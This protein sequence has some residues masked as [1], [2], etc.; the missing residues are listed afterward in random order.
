LA[1]ATSSSQSVSDDFLHLAAE[2]LRDPQSSEGALRSAISRAYYAVFISVRDQLFGPDATKLTKPI[3][4]QLNKRYQQVRRRKLELG[5]HDIIIFALTEI[6]HKTKLPVLTLSTQVGQLK[7][8]R[9]HAD[10]D[11]TSSNLQSVAKN[12]WRDYAEE[13]TVLA[14]QVL[15]LARRLPS[16]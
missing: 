8:A 16:Y 7:E 9:V 2:I 10:Y 11:F 1:L 5:S 12:S 15:P 6:R 13:T 3:R 14:S 4:K